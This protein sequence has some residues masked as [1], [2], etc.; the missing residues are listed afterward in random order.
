MWIL[1]LTGDIIVCSIFEKERGLQILK[2]LLVRHG[3]TDWNKELRYQGHRD[4]SLNATG[5]SQANRAGEIL[6]DYKPSALFASDLT[7]TLQTADIIGKKV[8]LTPRREPRL[9]EIHFGKW[10]GRTYPE[11]LELFPEEVKMWRECPLEAQVP[12]GETLRDV[13][14]RI[15]KALE[16]ICGQT[17]GNVVIV[18]HGG[19]IRLLLCHIGAEGAMWQY[20]VKPGSV[21]VVE[22]DGGKMSLVGQK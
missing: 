11:V 18:T 17:E 16:D 1:P 8:G 13:L 10:E 2:L 14:K 19:P 4:I 5:I 3:E 12:G 6:K 15:L 20:P 22:N 21:T 7:R 9:R